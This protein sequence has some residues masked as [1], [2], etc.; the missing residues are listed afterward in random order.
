MK[1]SIGV[2]LACLLACACSVPPRTGTPAAKGPAAAQ[3]A[4]DAAAEPARRAGATLYRIDPA[5]SEIRILVY[6]AGALG[7]LGHNHVLALRP[8]RGW[9]ESVTPVSGSTFFLE[10]PVGQVVVD[11]A[12]MRQQE[13][14]DF[15]GEIPEDARQGT[16]RNM[17]SEALLDAA[18]HPRLLIRSAAVAA[19]GDSF[20]AILHLSVAGYNSNVSAEF[21]LEETASSLVAGGELTLRQSELGLKPFSVM[22]GAL[23]VQDQIAIKFHIV[24]TRT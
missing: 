6:R 19:H 2:L 11:D 7:H 15:P 8:Q 17:L 14:A 9:V 24:A 23:Q 22:L 16:A 13:G 5:A 1:N 4:S 12:A 10:I 3:S 18:H 21:K 20:T